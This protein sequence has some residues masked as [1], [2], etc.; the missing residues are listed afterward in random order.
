MRRFTSLGLVLLTLALLASCGSPP[1]PD[2]F[3]L[4]VHLL[5]LDLEIIE[6]LRLRFSPQDL[7]TPFES[8][9][10]MTYEGGAITVHVDTDGALVMDI[11]GE[12][13]REL[14]MPSADGMQMIYPQQIWSEDET[15]N[16]PPIVFGTVYRSGEPIAEGMVYLP[17]WPP[18]LG[19]STQINVRCNADPPE[20]C[21]D[22]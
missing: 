8:Q 13:V 5:S 15:R 9:P 14:A 3:T 6:R 17:A 11:T 22:L 4:N 21:R 7:G 1:P 18:P 20:R 19:D 2:G 12:H 16:L 10:D